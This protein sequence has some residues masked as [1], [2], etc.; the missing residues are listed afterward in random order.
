M[1]FAGV[2]GR[3]GSEA[4]VATWTRPLNGIVRPPSSN[5]EYSLEELE[6]PIRIVNGVARDESL[7]PTITARK[8]YLAHFTDLRFIP[9]PYT[10][11]RGFIRYCEL[12]RVDF[13][14]ICNI[15]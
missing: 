15:D 2:V 11:D 7:P 12:N 1:H 3:D 13:L 6:E 4:L 9:L 10:D 5:N 8:T 14:S